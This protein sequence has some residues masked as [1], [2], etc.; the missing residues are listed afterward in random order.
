M[1]QP[2]TWLSF[3]LFTSLHCP[4]FSLALALR[5]VAD[6]GWPV[7]VGREPAVARN[8]QFQLDLT[9]VGGVQVGSVKI[10]QS[11][12][13]KIPLQHFLLKKCTIQLTYRKTI[14]FIFLCTMALIYKRTNSALKTK[15]GILESQKTKKAPSRF[16]CMSTNKYKYKTA[17]DPYGS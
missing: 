12:F 2:Y 16:S 7:G 9:G 4:L 6:R 14:C 1:I 15:K 3:C 5:S 10:H 13:L 8:F 11:L 17:L